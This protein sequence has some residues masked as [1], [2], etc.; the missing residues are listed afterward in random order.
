M[1]R[2]FTVDE[3]RERQT[4]DGGDSEDT[5]LFAPR[6]RAD[7]VAYHE[8]RD[9]IY[10]TDD[11]LLRQATRAEAQ[12]QG[13][14]PCW[15]CVLEWEQRTFGSPEKDKCPMCGEQFGGNLPQ[16]LQYDDC[17]GVA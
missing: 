1:S 2:S 12:D 3:L 9:C 15:H 11:G 14:A 16:H 8:S 17:G 4:R 5:V 13:L 6:H 10:V 7:P